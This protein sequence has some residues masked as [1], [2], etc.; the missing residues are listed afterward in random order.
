MNHEL[1]SRV[2]E[3]MHFNVPANGYVHRSLKDCKAEIKRLE[4]LLTTQG[5]VNLA[6]SERVS[7]LESELAEAKDKP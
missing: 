2:D 5:K 1:I 4:L 3:L 6:L 7:E